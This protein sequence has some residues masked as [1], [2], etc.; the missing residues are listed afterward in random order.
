MVEMLLIG[1]IAAA[2][3]LAYGSGRKKGGTDT[4]ADGGGSHAVHAR[5]ADGDHDGWDGGDHGGDGGD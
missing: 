2:F 4:G 5:Q 1:L 3:L